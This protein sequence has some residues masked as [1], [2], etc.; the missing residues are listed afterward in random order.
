MRPFVRTMSAAWRGPLFAVAAFAVLALTAACGD[1]ETRSDSPSTTGA[2]EPDDSG[3]PT[4]T[5]DGDEPTPADPLYLVFGVSFTPEGAFSYGFPTADISAAGAV[6]L[7]QAATAPGFSSFQVPGEPDG[8][9]LIGQS[10]SPVIDKYTISE[11]GEIELDGQVSLAGLGLQ[12]GVGSTAG[13]VWV[14]PSQAYIFDEVELLAV[15]FNPTTMELVSN[16]SIAGL[17]HEGAGVTPSFGQAR[18][19]GDRIVL[20]SRYFEGGVPVTETRLA[21]IDPSD[22]AVSYAQQTECANHLW[23]LETD[24]ALY[25]GPHP[26]QSSL[27]AAGLVDNAPCMKRLLRGADEYDPNFSLDLDSTIGAPAGAAVQG[28]GNIGYVLA[29]DAAVGGAI[30][31]DNAG[32]QATNT[33]AWNYVTVDLGTGTS[34][35]PL[36]GVPTGTGVGLGFEV[37]IDGVTVPFISAATSRAASTLFDVSDPDNVSATLNAPGIVLTVFRVR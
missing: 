24:E 21:F 5:G 13:I 35:G 29:Y 33:P 27:F 34:K 36:Q 15:E 22:N 2:G 9:F 28:P 30:T 1:D 31:V 16:F 18:V 10:E 20:M 11:T 3:E 32:S 25:F 14:S 19:D 8:T 26:N 4:D 17:G 23:L 7:E 6:D 37:E 12:S